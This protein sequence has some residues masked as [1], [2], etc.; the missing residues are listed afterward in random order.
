MCGDVAYAQALR[1]FAVS[2]PR[3]LLPHA[4]L[5]LLVASHDPVMA[6]TLDALRTCVALAHDDACVPTAL[7]VVARVL[8]R[9][10]SLPLGLRLLGDAGVANGACV[11]IAL[12]V[13]VGA[14]EVARTGGDGGGE[15]LPGR[16]EGAHALSTAAHVHLLTCSCAPFSCA[17]SS[18]PPPTLPPPLLLLSGFG[19]PS[20]SFDP[21]GPCGVNAAA[22]NSL[23]QC[24]H[25]PL[26]LSF[27]CSLGLLTLRPPPPS[28][29]PPPRSPSG[30]PTICAPAHTHGAVCP[31]PSLALVALHCLWRL[32]D[33]RPALCGGC[34]RA[35]SPVLGSS[36]GPLVSLALRCLGALCVG[37]VLSFRAL[38]AAVQAHGLLALVDAADDATVDAVSIHTRAHTFAGTD[39]MD[40]LAD[41]CGN[42]GI[43]GAMRGPFPGAGSGAQADA[44]SVFVAAVVPA[45]C[46]VLGHV[47]EELVDVRQAAQAVA[48]SGPAATQAVAPG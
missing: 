40:P 35:L 31:V 21:Y 43:D 7:S 1:L 47:V 13:L 8:S 44:H 46:D 9:P 5:L 23:M 32:C 36:E 30:L 45:L 42:A 28:P 38:H 10:T 12:D 24:S 41:D 25:P 15:C 27:V 48:A 22:G 11:P 16:P 26:P 2:H 3:C 17:G 14:L 34:V 29:P 4:P 18:P 19:T 20:S 37:G 6:H 33:A 39:C